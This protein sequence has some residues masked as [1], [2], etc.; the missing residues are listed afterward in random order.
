L[1][2]RYSTSFNQ[3]DYATFYPG[4]TTLLESIT[5]YNGPSYLT[6]LYSTTFYPGYTTLLE[7]IT[8]YNGPSY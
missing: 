3:V 1:A 6:L 2:L 4:Y 7:S 8:L 5:L